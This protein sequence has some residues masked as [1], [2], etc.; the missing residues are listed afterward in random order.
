MAVRYKEQLG[1]AIRE[2]RE[3]LGI[4][5]KELAE[6]ACVKEP[7]TVSRW[8]RGE[9]A[10]SDLEAVAAALQ[11]SIAE[12]MAGIEPPSR[13]AARKLNL[14]V[15]DS[16]ETQLDQIQAAVEEI[17]RL[18]TADGSAWIQSVE[19]LVAQVRSASGSP[20]TRGSGQ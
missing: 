15:A 18:L 10:P 4:T 7:Q 6:A 19:D 13:R 1:A 12:L 9:T 3:G 16:P 5:Q 20:P 8:E 2:R 14:V 17:K 11:C